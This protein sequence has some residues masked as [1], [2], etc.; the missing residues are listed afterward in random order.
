MI[1]IRISSFCCCIFLLYTLAQT[2]ASFFEVSVTPEDGSFIDLPPSI[3]IS[4]LPISLHIIDPN[5][6]QDLNTSLVLYHLHVFA[7]GGHNQPTLVLPVNMLCDVRNDVVFTLKNLQFGTHS[8]F[9]HLVSGSDHD[10][11]KIEW[12]GM[13]YT[14]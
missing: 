10:Q 1:M 14:K 11:K 12:S 5:C 7:N 9:M 6:R 8:L 13:V 3:T 2:N 4:D